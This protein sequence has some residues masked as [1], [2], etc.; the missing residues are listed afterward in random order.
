MNPD[1]FQKTWQAQASQTRLTIDA[2]LLLKEV[3]RNQQ[4]FTAMLIWRD[5]REVGLSLVMIPL[6]FYLGVKFS[7][8]WTWYCVVPALVWLGGFML[9]ELV[10]HRRLPPQPGEPLRQRV[11]SSLA[12]VEHQIWLLRN[13]HWW[14]L[15]PFALS[16]APFLAQVVWSDGA[17]GWLMRAFAM[18]YVV[19]V[20]ALTLAAVYW[21]NQ[22]AVRSELVPRRQE[23]EAL[24]AS[25]KDES[26]SAS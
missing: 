19:A 18:A 14:A 7:L 4:N 5:L 6:W 9:V 26:S 1:H 23:L 15:L 3:R 24:L 25:L 17:E 21:L 11:E 13:V 2:E 20:I 12:Q 22:N 16:S 8:P 10:R